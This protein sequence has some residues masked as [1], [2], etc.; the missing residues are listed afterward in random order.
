MIK[1]WYV[2]LLILILVWLILTLLKKRFFR[3]QLKNFKRL[4]VMS[5]FLLVSI[6]FLSQDVMGL[7]IIPFLICGL[8]A[9]G[10]FL[11]ILYVLMEGQI[12]YK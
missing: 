8:S 10:L 3:K 4:D 6:H 7:S 1:V 5:L 2:Q 11:S 9:Y 12:L